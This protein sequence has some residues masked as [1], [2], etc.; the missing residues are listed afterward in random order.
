MPFSVPTVYP[1]WRG[2]HRVAVSVLVNGGGLSPLARGT[3]TVVNANIA[4]FRF[5]PAGAGNTRCCS[6]GG[7]SSD[8]L[9]PLARGTPSHFVIAQAQPRFIPAGAGNTRPGA[10]RKSAT[11]VYP[12]WRG[13][14]CSKLAVVD[15]NI[16][17]SPL[18]RGTPALTASP[19]RRARFIPAGAGNTDRNRPA[20]SQRAVY[21][22]WR[23]EHAREQPEHLRDY[24]LS[25]LARGTQRLNNIF[26]RYARFIPAGAGNTRRRGAAELCRP[27]YPRWRGEHR[28]HW[29]AARD[30]RG[31]SPL[32]RGTQWPRPVSPGTSRF[33]PAGAGNTLNIY[34]CFLMPF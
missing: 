24:G 21:P 5:I 22:R 4:G 8:G 19:T 32:A 29:P 25:P 6:E 12:R 34:Y 17:L 16:G 15:E 13:E 30:V 33:I 20:N 10:N 14:H 31:L 18:A 9:S 11:P 1:R 7:C 28:S 2:E 23:G 26:D 27:V 3:L